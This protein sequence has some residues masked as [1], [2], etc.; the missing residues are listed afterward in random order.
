MSQPTTSKCH[1]EILVDPSLLCLFP[2]EEC[3]SIRELPLMGT[4]RFRVT[5]K[6]HLAH[7]TS[8]AMWGK[9]RVEFITNNGWKISGEAIPMAVLVRDGVGEGNLGMMITFCHHNQAKVEASE[10]FFALCQH[11]SLEPSVVVVRR[12]TN[13]PYFP[14]G[15][16]GFLYLDMTTLSGGTSSTQFPLDWLCLCRILPYSNTKVV[17]PWGRE[18]KG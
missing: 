16:F 17:L 4:L 18:R 14:W 1:E 8:P 6:R 15:S 7:L 10:V 2:E 11:V 12:F 5:L 3:K 13:S 9:A